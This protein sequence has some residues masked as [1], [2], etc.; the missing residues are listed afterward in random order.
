MKNHKSIKE[1]VRIDVPICQI[2]GET[3]YST[4]YGTIIGK[5]DRDTYHINIEYFSDVVDFKRKKKFFGY[6]KRSGRGYFKV[7][8]KRDKFYE[9][10][11]KYCRSEDETKIKKKVEVTRENISKLMENKWQRY[12]PFSTMYL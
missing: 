10:E 4:F 8:E 6:E 3:I 7:S 11:Q 5:T 12:D 9:I 2:W 1:F